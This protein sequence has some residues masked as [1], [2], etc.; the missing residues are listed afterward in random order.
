MKVRLFTTRQPV[1]CVTFVSATATEERIVGG[2]GGDADACSGGEVL[3]HLPAGGHRDSGPVVVAAVT[4]E[5]YAGADRG[6]ESLLHLLAGGL[7]HSEVVARDRRR[8]TWPGT[9]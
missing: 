2:D 6:C 5:L 8:G 4:D 1:D 7:H 9:P 3:H